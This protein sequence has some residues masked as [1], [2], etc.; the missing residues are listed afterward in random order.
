MNVWSRR[1]Y[2]VSSH[3][4]VPW[5]LGYLEEASK[6]TNTSPIFLIGRFERLTKGYKAKSINCI[7]TLSSIGPPGRR[8]GCLKK[9]KK[10]KVDYP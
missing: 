3:W 5:L 10:V 7:V 6:V 8:R 4:K 2:K 1:F 9:I